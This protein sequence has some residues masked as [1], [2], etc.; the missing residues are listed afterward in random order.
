M[1]LLAHWAK[2][3]GLSVLA[4]VLP[5]K[6]LLIGSMVMVLLD[7]LTGIMAARKRGEKITAAGLRRTV[8]KL[9]VYTL[10]IVSGS[11]A[12]KMLL[13][14]L[15]PVAKLVAGAIG[16]VEI[17]SVLENAQTVLGMTLFQA[18]MAR[19]GGP[20]DPKAVAEKAVAQVIGESPPAQ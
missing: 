14:A 6:P 18:L 1:T 8:T 5:I 11:V 13:D 20:T 3:V 12:E 2:I 9:A 15:V 7:C 4:F 16:I 10:A 17:K 19:L